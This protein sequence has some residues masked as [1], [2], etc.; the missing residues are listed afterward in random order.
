[1]LLSS[2]H[3][4]AILG[5]VTPEFGG[6]VITFFATTEVRR[7]GSA[8]AGCFAAAIRFYLTRLLRVLVIT[9]ADIP[10]DANDGVCVCDDF[11]I[12]LTNFRFASAFS[13]M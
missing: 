8:F 9:L 7:E 4:S 2:T 1:M 12:L 5:M 6:R 13:S 3:A 11:Y 10:C